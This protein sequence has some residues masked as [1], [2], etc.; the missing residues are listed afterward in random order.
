[1]STTLRLTIPQY[2]HM[3]TLGAFDSLDRH[4]EFIHGELREMNPAGPLHDDYIE[5]LLSWSAPL[6]AHQHCKARCQCG[7]RIGDSI[8]EPDF[9]L[10]THQRYGAQRPTASDVL[11]LIEVAE[12][13]L[14]YDLGEKAQLYATGGIAEYW[15]IDV[16]HQR[17]HRHRQPSTNGFQTIDVLES[18]AQVLPGFN[19]AIAIELAELFLDPPR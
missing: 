17:L 8:P 3:V 7:L 11:L 18:N 9:M 19:G 5:F 12:S 16:T 1:M 13:S 14:P 2:E 10:L 6:V 15:V 4:I